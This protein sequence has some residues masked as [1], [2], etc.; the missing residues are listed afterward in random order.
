MRVQ[1]Q[2]CLGCR[3]SNDSCGREREVQ[4]AAACPSHSGHPHPG[5]PQGWIGFVETCAPEIIPHV[6]SC[7]SPHMMVGSVLKTYFAEVC[8]SAV[9]PL[10]GPAEAV[11]LLGGGLWCAQGEA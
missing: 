1:H 11:Q 2:G 9:A 8:A 3:P 6:S 10:L 7:K 4:Q 5:L